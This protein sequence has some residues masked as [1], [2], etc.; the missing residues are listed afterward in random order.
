MVLMNEG[1]LFTVVLFLFVRYR[2]I[3]SPNDAG[4]TKTVIA[5]TSAFVIHPPL[6]FTWSRSFKTIRLTSQS[7]DSLRANLS[8]KRHGVT[9]PPGVVTVERMW[10]I[11]HTQKIRAQHSTL[12]RGIY[13]RRSRG[14]TSA[15][16]SISPYNSYS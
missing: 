16:A 11:F 5:H 13:K 4:Q 7:R 14:L 12:S 2:F 9:L 3:I 6:P 1:G 10:M 15:I 8:V